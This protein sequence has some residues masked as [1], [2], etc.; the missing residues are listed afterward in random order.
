ML[1]GTCTK[2]VAP[3]PERPPKRNLIPL[4]IV[5]GSAILPL[6]KKKKKLHQYFLTEEHQSTVGYTIVFDCSSCLEY[7]QLHIR[8]C[9]LLLGR[10]SLNFKVKPWKG[11]GPTAPALVLRV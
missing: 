6:K 8:R 4:G 2:S 10:V 9:H 3:I 11:A 7:I 5:F 1:C